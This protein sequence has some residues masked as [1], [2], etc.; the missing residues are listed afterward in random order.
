MNHLKKVLFGLALAMVLVLVGANNASADCTVAAAKPVIGAQNVRAE[1]TTELT[2]NFSLA[3]TAGI[4][5]TVSNVTIA[6]ASGTKV[7]A[8]AGT[9]A[10][11][12]G[13]IVNVNGSVG[14]AA[15]GIVT[16]GAWSNLCSATAPDNRGSFPCPSL[17]S[18]VAPTAAPTVTTSGTIVNFN[19]TPTGAAQTFAVNGVRVNVASTALNT[20]A[21]ITA[22]VITGGG[23]GTVS[24]SSI[25]F[26]IV[27]QTLAA[28][29]GFIN[30]T[31]LTLAACG[32]AAKTPLGTPA[33]F[34]NTVVPP[35]DAAGTSTLKIGL[36]EG[37]LGSFVTGLTLDGGALPSQ[38]SPGTFYV[39]PGGAPAGLRF[40]VS[41]TG[42]PSGFVVYAPELIAG[43]ASVG[44]SG[45]VAN[46][47]G[48]A[49]ATVLTLVTNNALDGSGGATLAGPVPGQF[50]L[51]TPSGGSVGVT[52]EVTVAAA[53]GAIEAVTVNV[54]LTGTATTGVG[55]INGV[56]S[57]A[58]VGPPTIN[59]NLP[60]YNPT[61]KAGVV[62]T[63]GLCASYLLFPW[64]ANTNDGNYDTGFAIA[65]TT[66][67]PSVIGSTGQTGDVTMYIFPSDG[68]AAITQSIA[69]ALKPGA[70]ATFVLSSLKKAITGYA[71]VVCNFTLGHGFAFIDNPIAGQNGFAEGY[72]ALSIFNPRIG[73][74][75][76]P[77]ES[78][79]H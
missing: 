47:T 71:I 8:G 10:V 34:L 52:Y 19:F 16:A 32:P 35:L 37:F 23:L 9:T 41:L 24:N 3:C 33:T 64:I 66:S 75:P 29:S 28:G 63:V 21:A 51:V 70:T 15:P 77:T 46:S 1:G 60:Q 42:I 39:A 62:A 43:L 17:S 30:A 2:A 7:T 11:I 57:L 38:A 14:G 55:A 56:V 20:G 12:A 78:V 5:T 54:V 22:S 36:T 53:I 74:L 4:T 61:T 79:G 45:S 18:N 67:D 59:P 13:T 69:T 68:S 27:Q 26:G 58:P 31:T 50:D 6:F 48:A 76:N 40:R 72:L 25:V 65:N 44:G 73:G 49:G